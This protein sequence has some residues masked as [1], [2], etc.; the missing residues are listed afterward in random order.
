MGTQQW[1]A[2]FKSDHVLPMLE[3]IMHRETFK[4]LILLFMVL[5]DLPLH[6]HLIQLSVPATLVLS[7]LKHTRVLLTLGS[8]L[9]VFPLLGIH[10]PPEHCKADFLI[11]GPQLKENLSMTA[12]WRVATPLSFHQYDVFYWSTDYH[13]VVCLKKKK[14]V[15]IWLLSTPLTCNHLESSSALSTGISAA[16]QIAGITMYSLNGWRNKYK[17]E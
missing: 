15:H 14:F 4:P 3:L 13:H 9:W 17:K 8:W 12:Q 7:Y 11:L 5:C 1:L 6:P 10:I 2:P 16:S